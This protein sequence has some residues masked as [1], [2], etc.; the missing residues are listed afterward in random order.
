MKIRSNNGATRMMLAGIPGST[1]WMVFA[2]LL[3]L[4]FTGAFGA[5]IG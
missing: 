4:L 5:L 3:G 2:M 1:G